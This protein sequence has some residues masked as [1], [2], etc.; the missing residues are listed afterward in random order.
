MEKKK[1]K[2]K[3]YFESLF[4]RLKQKGICEK[5]TQLTTGT[6]HIDGFCLLFLSTVYEWHALQD[7]NPELLFLLFKII[8]IRIFGESE[9]KV[10]F[11]FRLICINGDVNRNAWLPQLINKQKNFY[12]NITWYSIVWYVIF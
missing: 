6:S 2:T 4:M 1:T 5:L 3:N 11:C 8:Q 7:K 9:W 10:F 12:S